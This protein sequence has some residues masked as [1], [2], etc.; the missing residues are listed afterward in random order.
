MWVIFTS[1]NSILTPKF[2]QKRRE[3]YVVHLQA[4]VPQFQSEGHGIKSKDE[5]YSS[6]GC[7]PC[8]RPS[9]Q[10]RR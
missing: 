4:D 8:R 6:D 9:V 3:L 10:I 5:I 7:C 1:V 2:L